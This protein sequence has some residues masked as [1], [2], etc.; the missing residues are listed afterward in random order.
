M[1]NGQPCKRPSPGFHKPVVS[2]GYLSP[3][4][5]TSTW[6]LK[7][8]RAQVCPISHDEHHAHQS[9]AAWSSRKGPSHIQPFLC[10]HFLL[11]KYTYP[12]FRGLS[13]PE[14]PNYPFNFP[15]NPVMTALNNYWLATHLFPAYTDLCICTLKGLNYYIH[16]NVLLYPLQQ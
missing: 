2:S 12:Y 4:P 16:I 3:A 11:N 13:L 1:F 7:T 8:R 15:M 10:K 9:L 6:S 14:V 5:G